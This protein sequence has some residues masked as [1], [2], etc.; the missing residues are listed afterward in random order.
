MPLYLQLFHRFP[1][2]TKTLQRFHSS[3]LQIQSFLMAGEGNQ[4]KRVA[5]EIL[6]EDMPMNQHL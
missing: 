4:G 3:F 5:E 2:S 1:P 6:A